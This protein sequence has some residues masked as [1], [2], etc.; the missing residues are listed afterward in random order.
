M[1]FLIKEL[2]YSIRFVQKLIAD[3]R[4]RVEE[5][6]NSLNEKKAFLIKCIFYAKNGAQRVEDIMSKKS[7]EAEF[8]IKCIILSLESNPVNKRRRGRRKVKI[9]MKRRNS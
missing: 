5:K 1:K 9:C 2:V 8:L 7:I 6:T 3:T 4:H